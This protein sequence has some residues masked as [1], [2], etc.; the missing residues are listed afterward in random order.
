MSLLQISVFLENKPGS[1]AQVADLLSRNN[2]NMRAMSVAET[3]RFGILRMIVDEYEKTAAVL[4]DNGYVFKE[5]PV[6]G[7][8]VEDKPGSLVTILNIL[9][10]E[11]INLEY[12][13]AFITSKKDSAYL[14]FRVDDPDKT[15]DILHNKGY[16]L[17]HSV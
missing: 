3:D 16:H 12:M 5:V 14:V 9:R 1:F 13:Y 8:E 7:I 4:T 2:I 10:E 15:T 11:Q 17:L 6:L